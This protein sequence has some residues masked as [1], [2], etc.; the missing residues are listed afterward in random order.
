MNTVSFDDE[1][2]TDAGADGDVGDRLNVRA[3]TAVVQLADRRRIDVGV[4]ADRHVGKR[5]AESTDDVRVRPARLRRRR[6][7]AVVGRRST[8]RERAEARDADAGDVAELL[9]P[10]NDVRARLVGRRRRDFARLNDL[11]DVVR[12]G[13]NQLER[14]AAKPLPVNRKK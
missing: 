3:V 2:D 10:R 4:E 11:C 14:R 1:S 7:V 9:D 5:V 8:Q 12:M 6:D 13:T